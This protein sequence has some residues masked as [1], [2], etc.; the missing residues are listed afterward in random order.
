MN[1]EQIK[2]Q[3][4]G[5]LGDGQGNEI[6][7][8]SEYER[9]ICELIARIDPKEDMPTSDRAEEVLIELTQIAQA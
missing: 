6:G 1:I 8:N 7:T 4:A 5:L 9:G 3:A 2:Q